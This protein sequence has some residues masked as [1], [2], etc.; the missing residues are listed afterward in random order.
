MPMPAAAASRGPAKRRG[1]AS[2][3]ISPSSG[4]SRPAAT[5]MSVDLPAPFAPSSATTPPASTWTSTPA[6]A[7]TRLSPSP[8][9]LPIPR[10]ARSGSITARSADLRQVVHLAGLDVL[11]QLLDLGLVLVR[12]LALEVAIRRDRDAILLE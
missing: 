10:N 11:D 8:K 4:C 5:F 7:V 3:R 1:R 9:R 12:D 6:S 2:M